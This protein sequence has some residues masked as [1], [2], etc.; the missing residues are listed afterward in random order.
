[1]TVQKTR[2]GFELLKTRARLYMTFQ[3]R[4]LTSNERVMPDFMVIGGQKCG[5]TS[6]HRYIN[7]HPNII[8]TFKKD[9]SFYDANYFRG[10]K[11]YRAH[12]P[13]KSKMDEFQSHGERFITGEVTTSYIHHPA[14]P[15]RIYDTLP[16]VK[17]IALLRNPIQRAYSHYQH[18]VRTGRETL[19]FKEAIEQEDERLD[20]VEEKV[21]N[22]D[23]AALKAFR[24]F[25]YKSRGRY[26]EQLER[27]FALFPKEQFLIL[28]S[29][30]L[31]ANPEKVT[32]EVY[33]FLGIPHLQLEQYQNVNPGNY[34]SAESDTINL[35]I[36]YFR[37]H[38]QK[39][40]EL[41]GNNFGW[42][43]PG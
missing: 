20:R 31:F 12:F 14:T 3:Y 15:Q 26:A 32:R 19:S 41:L 29:E 21:L 42:E 35:L 27:W 25:S 2:K 7:Q 11:W 37:P 39:L 18:M 43:N 6:L 33:E 24:N 8:P 40:A 9:S 10:F 1:M 5:T 23:D 28:R 34:P 36:E 17:F 4:L 16:N 22:G 30:D 13:L 38:N